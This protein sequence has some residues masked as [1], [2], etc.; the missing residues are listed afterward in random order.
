M[1]LGNWHKALGISYLRGVSFILLP[2][3]S[4]LSAPTPLT[5]PQFLLQLHVLLLEKPNSVTAVRVLTSPPPNPR[6]FRISTEP[7]NEG[8]GARTLLLQLS[9]ALALTETW[10]GECGAGRE[11]A[12]AREKPGDH[13]VNSQDQGK[14]RLCCLP[15][16]AA[17]LEPPLPPLSPALPQRPVSHRPLCISQS[18][19]S[20]P[21]TWDLGST[22]RRR[23]RRSQPLPPRRLPLFELLGDLRVPTGP[24]GVPVLGGGLRGRLAVRA[25]RQRRHDTEDGAAG[26]MDRAGGAEVLGGGDTE[27][28]ELRVELPSEPDHPASLL[29]PEQGWILSSHRWKRMDITLQLPEG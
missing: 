15:P 19:S 25:L 18:H 20:P 29:Q 16:S 14:P 17:L 10:A 22:T 23:V 1:A 24:R 3:G 7:Q 9:E 12:S 6:G 2:T 5:R 8:D 21:S 11:L 28:P 27:S 4:G 26:A 13:L